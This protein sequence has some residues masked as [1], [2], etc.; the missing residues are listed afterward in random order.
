MYGSACVCGAFFISAKTA[1]AQ[2][3]W[4]QKIQARLEITSTMLGD[5]KAVKMLGLSGI[6]FNIIFKLRE[7]ELRASSHFRR[8]LVLIV[9]LCKQ[10]N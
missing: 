10:H 8:L 1:P 2:K 7:A 4:V 5:M 9:A 3:A 6:L